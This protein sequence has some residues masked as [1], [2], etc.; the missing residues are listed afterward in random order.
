MGAA[1]LLRSVVTPTPEGDW[2]SLATASRGEYG[3]PE[4]LQ[5]GYPI[6]SDGTACTVV[7][8]IEHDD[9]AR[10]RIKVT[11]DELLEERGEVQE[12]LPG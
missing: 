3:I 4:G 1:T 5:F 10:E 2:H 6:R 12:L 8:G 11:T 7:E 9:W